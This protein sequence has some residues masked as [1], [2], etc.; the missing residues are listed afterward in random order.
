MYRER[1]GAS[2]L[3][4][5]YFALNPSPSAGPDQTELFPLQCFAYKE[6]GAGRTRRALQSPG[7]RTAGNRH[8]TLRKGHSNKRREIIGVFV[9]TKQDGKWRV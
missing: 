9:N 1:K 7:L 3:G 6:T 8:Q 5:R 2:L 4:P